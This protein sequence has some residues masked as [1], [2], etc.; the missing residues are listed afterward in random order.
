MSY[1]IV[2][3]GVPKEIG[4]DGFTAQNGYAYP[5]IVTTLWPQ[6]DLIVIG[7]YPIV[8]PTIPPHQRIVSTSLRYASGAVYRDAVCEDIPLHERKASLINKIRAKRW[9][10]ETGGVTVGGHVVISDER[11]QAKLTGAIA[12]F[13]NDSTLTTIDWEA[14]PAGTYVSVDR[15]TLTAIGVAMG[16]HVQ[17]CFSRAKALIDAV[18]AA[19]DH[20]TIDG[21]D[22]SSGWPS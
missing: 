6:S 20:A 12:L 19:Q 10:V 4:G 5:Y 7:V 17:A 8:E 22:I 15:A 9:A 16:R 1:A 14:T 13:Q 3:N 11:S 2:V 18:N 21:I